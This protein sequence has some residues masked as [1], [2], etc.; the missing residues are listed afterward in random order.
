MSTARVERRSELETAVDKMRAGE[1]LTPRER[2]LVTARGLE[3][4]ALTDEAPSP[5]DEGE[6]LDPEE[7]E[8]LLAALVEA[9]ADDRERR[10][11]VPWRELFPPRMAG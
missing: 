8:S 3:L 10:L 9:D 2:E 5:N 11:G 4:A 6:K 7:E 1:Q